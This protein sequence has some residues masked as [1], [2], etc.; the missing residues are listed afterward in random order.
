MKTFAFITVDGFRIDVKSSTPISGYRK[1]IKLHGEI[2][3]KSYMKYNKDG[4]GNYTT[5][6]I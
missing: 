2:I 3:T 5:Y 4:F 6:S 1:L